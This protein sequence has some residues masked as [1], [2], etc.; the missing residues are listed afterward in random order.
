MLA[1]FFQATGVTVVAERLHR[2][3]F[4]VDTKR[5]RSK[6][7]STA[8][9]NDPIK[10]N[11]GKMPEDENE[12]P[13][14]KIQTPKNEVQ[15]LGDNINEPEGDSLPPEDN[16]QMLEDRIDESE[17]LMQTEEVEVLRT[18]GKI[19]EMENNKQIS[20][21]D[22]QRPQDIIGEVEKDI[23]ISADNV[24]MAEDKIERPEDRNKKSLDK[25]QE[26]FRKSLD[27]RPHFALPELAAGQLVPHRT[28]KKQ[29]RYQNMPLR[30]GDSLVI[31]PA[32]L[33]AR[34]ELPAVV[35]EVC[36]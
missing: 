35:N 13:E 15:R 26:S 20:G 28:K 1:F 10:A 9:V 18:E 17:E 4:N 30:K 36:P 16:A 23:Q 29:Q 32:S 33:A 14:K 22:M 12:K 34:M 25:V 21:D 6:E 24:Q 2:K 27:S 7:S 31:N 5:N 3:T 11:I 19:D 8:S